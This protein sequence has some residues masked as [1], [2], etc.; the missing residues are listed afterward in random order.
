M[1][2]II[3]TIKGFIIGIAKIIPGVSGAVLAISMGLYDKAIN[4]IT[5]FFSN[6]KKNIA[7]LLPIAIGIIIAMIIGSSIVIS[8]LTNHYLATMLFFIGLIGGS[9]PVIYRKTD[10]TKKGLLIILIS[11][12]IMFIISISNIN[13]TYEV[14]DSPFDYFIYFISGII[15]AIGTVIPGISSTA[16]LMILGTY[17]IIINTISNLTSINLFIENSK[18]IIFYSFGMLIGIIIISLL[19]NYLF[20]KYNDKTY[21]AILGIILSSILLLIIKAFSITIVIQDLIIGITL[22]ALGIIIA[23]YFDS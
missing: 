17:D 3:L 10:K 14:K 9:I 7:F 2:T 18:V 20:K 6:P 8:S 5:E 13:N 4:A 11:F 23:F 21:S 15:D 19:I 16:L 1:K 12:L 22:L